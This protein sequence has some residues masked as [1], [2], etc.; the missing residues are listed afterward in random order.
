M[1]LYVCQRL[2]VLNSSAEDSRGSSLFCT[3][4]KRGKTN[5]SNRETQ[6]GRGRGKVTNLPLFLLFSNPI[7][8]YTKKDFHPPKSRGN[9]CIVSGV[10]HNDGVFMSGVL[11]QPLRD[12]RLS[13]S[14]AES[15]EFGHPFSYRSTML[16]KSVLQRST[17]TFRRCTPAVRMIWEGSTQKN[18]DLLCL[19]D[20]HREDFQFVS[21]KLGKQYMEEAKEVPTFP[22]KGLLYGNHPPGGQRAARSVGGVDDGDCEHRFY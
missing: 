16:F 13:P 3:V 19:Q 8:I 5:P 12:H 14:V 7:F 4:Y 21:D 6:G 15:K 22:V 10:F 9:I 17:D 18:A 11:Q 1:Y 2:S 20:M